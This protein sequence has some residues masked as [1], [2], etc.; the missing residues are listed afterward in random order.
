MAFQES[1]V[2]YVDEFGVSYFLG[3]LSKMKVE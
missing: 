2:H 3:W 1:T